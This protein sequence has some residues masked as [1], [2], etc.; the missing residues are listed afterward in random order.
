MDRQS[1]LDSMETWL[2]QMGNQFETAAESW[3]SGPDTWSAQMDQPR[4]DM[5]ER[6]GEYVIE[7][8]LPGFSKE[9]VDV[10]LSDGTLSIEAERSEELESGDGNFLKRERSHT[11]LSRRVSL[12]GDADPDE[13]SASLNAG[14]LTV[15]VARTQPLDSGHEIDIE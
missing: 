5:V 6:D 1:P 8:E 13:I 2:E 3:G 14:V 9:D 12:P 10:Y 11:T 7:A 15:T 4:L